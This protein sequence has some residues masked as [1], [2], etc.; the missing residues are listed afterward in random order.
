MYYLI[1]TNSLKRGSSSFLESCWR[2]LPLLLVLTIHVSASARA[3][4]VSLKM[5]NATVKE[6]LESL[7]K[8]TGLKFLFNNADIEKASKISVSVSNKPL[9]ELLQ[10]VLKPIGLSYVIDDN[11][12]IIKKV[13]QVRQDRT[14]TGKVS[15][16]T[17]EALPGVTVQVKGETYATTTNDKGTYSIK[18]RDSKNILV[19]SFVGHQTKEAEIGSKEVVNMVLPSANTDLQEV[20]IVGYGQVAKKDLTGAVSQVNLGELS[21]APVVAFDQ[22]LAGRMAGVKVSTAEDGQPGS[23]MSIVIRGANSLTQTNAPLYVVDGF[24]I[25]NF[26]NAGVNTDDI[27]SLTV[28]KDASS[29]AIYGA[30]GANGVIVIETKKGKEGRP[31]ISY[32][33]SLGFNE[34]HKTIDMLNP[35][36]FVRYEMEEGRYTNSDDKLNYLTDGKTLDSYKGIPGIDWQGRMFKQGRTQIHN[37]ALR[38]G[39]RTTK[40][41]ISGSIFNSEGVVIN[42]GYKRYQ[43]RLSLDQTINKKLK[44]GANL[45]FNNQ[46]TYGQLVGRSSATASTT[47]SGYLLYSVWGYRPVSTSAGLG[48]EDLQ[49]GII[50]GDVDE[51]V[52]FRINPIVSA[53]NT[54]RERHMNN[55]TAN[56]NADYNFNPDLT[57]KVTGGFYGILG[58]NQ[59]FYNSKTVRGT[60]LRSNNINGVNG[61]IYYSQRAD[62]INEN[63][64]TWKKKYDRHRIELMGGFTWQESRNSTYGF[65]SI[66]VPNEDLGINGLSQGSP[67]E[68]T[69]ASTYNTLVSYVSRLNYSYRTKYLLTATFRADGSSKFSKGNRW[70]YF[71][72]AALAWR[73]DREKFLKNV[74][75]ISD[76]KL[77]LSYGITGN[78]RVSDFAYLPA[79]ALPDLGSYSFNNQ[80]LLGLNFTSLGNKDLKWESTR[81]ID[82]G[83]DLGLFKDR[84]SLTADVYQK[85]T[86]DLLLNAPIPYTTGYSRVYK[87]IGKIRNEGLELTLNTRNVSSKNFYWNSNFN[88][89]FNK[90][91]IMALTEDQNN[92]HSY[93]SSFV[94]RMA[95]EPLYIAEVGKSAAR[96][97]GLVWDGVYQYEDF[98]LLSNGAYRLK[99]NITTNGDLREFIKPGD[100][101]YKDMNGDLVVDAYDKTVIGNPNPKHYGGF[102]NS[103]GYKGVE[104]SVHMQWSYGNEIMNANRLIFEGNITNAPHVNQYASWA[105]RWTPENQNNTLFRTGGAGPQVMSSRTLEDG[106]YLRLKTV[107]LGYNLPS[108]WLKR[109]N[110]SNINLNVAAQ[111]FLTWTKYSGLDPEVSVF[112][113]VLTPGFDFSAYPNARTLVFGLKV[114]F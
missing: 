4:N 78:N 72:S 65:S 82:L 24:P 54:F 61:G 98:D 106:S 30:R 23:E 111:N 113:S 25:E 33:S 21:K 41:S 34:V 60:P 27:E 32:S 9:S 10:E 112:N 68:T 75:F 66:L 47:I 28:L 84:I 44:V 94:S 37:I 86:F 109:V 31:V 43:G 20:V 58:D 48:E 89:S 71:P 35:Y 64:L 5:E 93:I 52:D 2:M 11:T 83:Y 102:T 14:I 100:I 79:A 16:E 42:T 70:A 63:T 7:N 69:T 29:T 15:A 22:A 85:T 91:K 38:G 87:N 97:Y 19:F 56:V 62:W 92:M 99:N 96:F 17:G 12:V 88:I 13:K 76:S 49:S 45:N 73:M 8:Q 57:L 67:L 59:E 95:E 110:I 26:Q 77:R 53:E 3:Q 36:E 74:R 39:T 114:Q 101:K 6:V 1:I 103:F 90:N 81:Q 40:Y 51:T 46:E 18:V 107:S 108:T 105:N 55:L 50:D 104:L 80:R